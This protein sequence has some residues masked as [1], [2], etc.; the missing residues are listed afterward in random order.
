MPPGTEEGR[1]LLAHELAHVVQQRQGPAIDAESVEPAG[2]SAEREAD[3]AAS[4]ATRG[5]A[6][7][8]LKAAPAG[9]S[10]DTGS[11]APAPLSD[12]NGVGYNKILL[13]AGAGALSAVQDLA[14]LEKAGKGGPDVDVAKFAALPSNAALD[15]LA[16]QRHAAGTGCEPW[17]PK[18]LA[19]PVALTDPYG[20]KPSPVK[21]FVFAGQTDRRALV[22]GGVH[23]KTEPQGAAV[24]EKMRTLL[25]ARAKAKKPPFFTTVLVPNLFDPSR[26][27]PKSE[28]W[29]RAD[30]VSGSTSIGSRGRVTRSVE[31]N[32]N[33]PLP[34]EDLDAARKRGVAAGPELIFNDPAAPGSAPRGGG[35]ALAWRTR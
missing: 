16:L 23:N 11:G 35:A 8:T 27:D 18:L 26:Y 14:S 19:S 3:V 33:F 24:V 12:P 5:H 10:R 15:V 17:F 25:T 32:R 22:I 2:S 4:A 1:T 30:A 20:G 7:A 21:A 34:G 13:R 29:I 6:P 31:P 28:R 9:I